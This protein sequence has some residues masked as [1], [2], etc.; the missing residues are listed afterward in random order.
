MPAG[1]VSTFQVNSTADI[2]SIGM[3]R[4]HLQNGTD[5]TS[6]IP[7]GVANGVAAAIA[8]LY[9]A[10]K[11][12]FP[13]T[14][15]YQVQSTQ[16]IMDVASGLVQGSFSYPTVPGAVVG[17]GVG[18]Y[19]GGNGARGYWH[20]ATV[21]NRRVCRGATY[22]TPFVQAAWSTTGGLTGANSLAITNAMS[23]Y[24]TAAV[25]AGAIPVVYHRPL[26]GATTGGIAAPITG[27][28]CGVQPGSLRS[29][30]V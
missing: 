24:I 21:I 30:R 17:T 27:A 8:A 19:A 2:G 16:S 11:A 28:S 6:P 26:K 9:T 15:S 1:L 20:T 10:I 18:T 13:T 5:P 22:F 23:A 12:F 7:N 4:F 25:A 3:S 29:R 14:M